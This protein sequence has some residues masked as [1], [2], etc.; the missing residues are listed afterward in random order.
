M[1]R[2]G[3]DE[4]ARGLLVALVRRFPGHPMRGELLAALETLEDV[5]RRAR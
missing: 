3:R 5:A 2:L 1:D 4:E